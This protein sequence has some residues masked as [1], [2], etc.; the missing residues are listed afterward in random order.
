M[1][2][3]TDFWWTFIGDQAGDDKGAGLGVLASSWR[4]TVESDWMADF[5]VQVRKKMADIDCY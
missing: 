2:H 5:I 4:Y 3:L 1:I